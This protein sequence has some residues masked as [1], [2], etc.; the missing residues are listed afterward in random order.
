MCD[1][2]PQEYLERVKREMGKA[3]FISTGGE[4][5]DDSTLL[6]YNQ[7]LFV[8]IFNGEL[9]ASALVPESLRDAKT[10]GGLVALLTGNEVLC[11]QR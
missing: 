10:C 5:W 4:R 3:I 8:T 2:V 9:Q 1:Y 11:P 6:P 7:V